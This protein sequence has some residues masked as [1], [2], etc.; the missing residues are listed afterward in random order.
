MTIRDQVMEFVKRELGDCATSQGYDRWLY[1]LR[2]LREYHLMK[3]PEK[4]GKKPEESCGACRRFALVSVTTDDEEL[5]EKAAKIQRLFQ[6][7]VDDSIKTFGFHEEFFQPGV[8][9]I[10]F[11]DKFYLEVTKVPYADIFIIEDEFASVGDTRIDWT[12]L[13]PS[14]T[15]SDYEKLFGKS[16]CGHHR[17]ELVNNGN[18]VFDTV[19]RACRKVM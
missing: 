16:F 17:T 4:V 12:R 18:D 6:F 1:I 8:K 7:I 2:V 3:Q 5:K 15:V 11:D 9:K 13:S 19:C 14:P 10:G